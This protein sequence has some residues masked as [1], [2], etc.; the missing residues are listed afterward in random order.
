M[1]D[2]ECPDCGALGKKVRWNRLPGVRFAH[3]IEYVFTCNN[4]YCARSRSTWSVIKPEGEVL[5]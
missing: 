5:T 4:L 1:K 3:L 2:T